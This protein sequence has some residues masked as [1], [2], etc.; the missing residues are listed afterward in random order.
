MFYNN[1]RHITLNFLLSC[2]AF[3]AFLLSHAY[4][5]ALA[6]RRQDEPG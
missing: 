3:L 2:L 4:T 1:L 5:H 6:S